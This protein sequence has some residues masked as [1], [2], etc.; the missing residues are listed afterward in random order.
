MLGV[1]TQTKDIYIKTKSVRHEADGSQA[2][3]TGI[4]VMAS[5]HSTTRM[6]SLIQHEDIRT[7]GTNYFTKGS[8]QSFPVVVVHD[9]II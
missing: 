5:V 1:I 9:A 4:C 6:L 7:I 2:R 3:V 8:K